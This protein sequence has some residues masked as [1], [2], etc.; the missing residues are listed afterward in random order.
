MGDPTAAE[1]QRIAAE[2]LLGALGNFTG[3]ISEGEENF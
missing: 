2:N 1:F 3:A